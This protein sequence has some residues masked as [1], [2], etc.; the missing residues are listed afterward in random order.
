MDE[1]IVI[2][3][4]VDPLDWIDTTAESTQPHEDTFNDKINSFL[5]EL[6]SM[7]TS[8]LSKSREI[9]SQSQ[10]N[11][12]LDPLSTSPGKPLRPVECSRTL[13]MTRDVRSLQAVTEGISA[14]VKLCECSIPMAAYAFHTC[15]GNVFT[16]KQLLDGKG[17]TPW[18]P[19]EDR[20]VCSRSLSN[21]A[22]L[23]RHRSPRELHQRISY[24]SLN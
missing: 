15:S 17:G 18:T 2:S 13:A 24:Y 22:V 4:Q 16:A 7:V 21:Y 8:S 10:E 1:D 9:S 20:L 14:L 6:D 11:L 23:L 19:D 5:S 3:C 12:I